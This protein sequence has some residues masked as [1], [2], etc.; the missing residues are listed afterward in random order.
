MNPRAVYSGRNVGQ[1][2]PRRII[3]PPLAPGA[4]RPKY[5]HRKETKRPR[6]FRRRR[7]VLLSK[8]PPPIARG[9]VFPIRLKVRGMS[10]R[11]RHGRD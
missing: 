3:S 10:S 5:P 11:H 4:Q 9:L 8:H 7:P 1:P 6:I 2:L